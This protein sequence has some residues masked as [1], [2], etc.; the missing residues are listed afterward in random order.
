M[1]TLARGSFFILICSSFQGQQYVCAG[2]LVALQTMTNVLN[3]FKVQKI[4]I[5]KVT[6]CFYWT[7]TLLTFSPQLTET[8]TVEKVKEMLAEII[9]TCF[10]RAKEQQ[11]AEGFIKLERGFATIPL[12]GI[13][14]P[15]HSRYLWAGVMPFRACEL[16]SHGFLPLLT[17]FHRPFQED[18]PRSSEP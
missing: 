3:Y 6:S 1:L 12:P 11:K 17:V 18:Q 10:D 15:F 8:F 14:V 5:A 7:T 4:D 2:E 9:A 16:R 13:D